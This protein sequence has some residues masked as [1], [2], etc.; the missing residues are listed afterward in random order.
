MPHAFIGIVVDINE[1]RLPVARKRVIVNCKPM[2]L[3]S[4]VSLIGTYPDDRLVVTPVAIF[5][6]CRCQLLMQVP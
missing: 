3:R 2:I 4:D 1:E 5:S 6:I